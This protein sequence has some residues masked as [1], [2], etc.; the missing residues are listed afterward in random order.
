MEDTMQNKVLKK[1]KEVWNKDRLSQTSR[2]HFGVG[3]LCFATFTSILALGF[4]VTAFATDHWKHI[5]VNRI[6]LEYLI[7]KSKD[8][9]DEKFEFVNEHRYYDRVEGL[10]QVCFPNAEKPNG[11]PQNIFGN[12]CV[13]KGFGWDYSWKSNFETLST[14]EAWTA[15]NLLTIITFGFYFVFMGVALVMGMIGCVLYK[16]PLYNSCGE[17]SKPEYSKPKYRCTSILMGLAIVPALIGMGFFHATNF[18]ERNMVSFFCQNLFLGCT[19]LDSAAS[20]ISYLSLS[21]SPVMF[22]N[23][24]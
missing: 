5:S 23:E 15:M 12:S 9:M 10:F 14:G 8:P 19:N 20:E 17:V 3:C 21:N 11:I 18:Y 7:K 24:Y 6:K 16:P 22:S 1:I 2:N 13:F 4:F